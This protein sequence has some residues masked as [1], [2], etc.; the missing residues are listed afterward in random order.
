MLFGI[1]LD[2]PVRRFRR[3]RGW[4]ARPDCLEVS[5][6]KSCRILVFLLLLVVTGSPLR[7]PSLS[8]APATFPS[9]LLC[10]RPRREKEEEEERVPV[11]NERLPIPDPNTEG[12]KYRQ[13]MHLKTDGNC[14]VSKKTVWQ[15]LSPPFN[16]LR[17]QRNGMGAL[18]PLPLPNSPG[19]SPP[20][21]FLSKQG[22]G[23]S[24]VFLTCQATKTHLSRLLILRT[25]PPHP[26]PPSAQRDVCCFS[27]G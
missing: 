12:K 2:F 19:L 16:L 22:G 1:R 21:K 11:E 14:S 7:L 18:V 26:H 4:Q 9:R 23:G 25:P 27:L 24:T 5:Y 15:N 20:V 10:K 8:H 17:A 6:T 3:T 13:Q